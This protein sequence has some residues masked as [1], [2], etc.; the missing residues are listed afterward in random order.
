MQNRKR[1]DR[2]VHPQHEGLS[3]LAAGCDS[4]GCI[5]RRRRGERGRFE[6]AALRCW[7]YRREKTQ[8]GKKEE[9]RTVLF[10]AFSSVPAFSMAPTDQ[11]QKGKEGIAVSAS[12]ACS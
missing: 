1:E 8:R 7:L 9:E 6:A 3:G 11:K 12:G 4:T 5:G 2:G 10:L